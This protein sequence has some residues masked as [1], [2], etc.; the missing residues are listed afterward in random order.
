MKIG[1]PKEIKNNEARVAMTPDGVAKLV[2]S[3]NSVVIEKNAGVGSGFI[4]EQYQKAGATLVSTAEAWNVD[5]VVKVKE[6]QAS[7]YQY[8]GKQI[9]FTFFHLSGVDIN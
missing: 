2:Q 7:E 1:V 4:N 6:P 3:G 9:V 5:M 8:I